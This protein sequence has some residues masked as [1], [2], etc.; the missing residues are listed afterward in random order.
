MKPHLD[1]VRV[2][3]RIGPAGILLLACGL[4]AAVFSVQQYMAVS[5]ELAAREHLRGSDTRPAAR[6]G[7]VP[8]NLDQLRARLVAANQVL[9]KRTTPWD[10]LFRDIEA[11]SDKKIGLL[12]VQPEIAG[13]VVRITGEAHDAAALAEYITHLE[14]KA[15]LANVHLTEH[16]TRQDSGRAVIRFGLSAV[17]T[18][19]PA[20]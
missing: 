7:A 17:W 9:E 6:P 15:S 14:E 10:A 2:P 18:M 5:A 12:S 19:E 8:V 13:R 1:F 3:S 16:E 4:G 11:V 20:S